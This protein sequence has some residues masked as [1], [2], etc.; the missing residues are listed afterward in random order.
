M[1]ECDA[2]CVVLELMMGVIVS[3]RVRCALRCFGIVSSQLIFI[4][5]S[6]LV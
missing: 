4:T 5:E 6:L 3:G 2:D 1:A